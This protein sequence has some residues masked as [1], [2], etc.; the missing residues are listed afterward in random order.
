MVKIAVDIDTPVAD[1]AAAYTE[2]CNMRFDLNDDLNQKTCWFAGDCD[3]FE[4]SKEQDDIAFKEFSDIRM[5]AALKL[6]PGAKEALCSLSGMGYEIIYITARPKGMRRTTAKWIV[7]HGLPLDGLVFESSNKG[8]IASSIGCTYAIDDRLDYCESFVK[9]GIITYLWQKP[10]SME[11][12]DLDVL[13][14]N[15]E[16]NCDF[17]RWREILK[18]IHERER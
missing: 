10:Y 3:N 9:Q 2:Y 12:G 6:V 4:I 1:F 14:I 11:V 7:K 16:K 13:T 15:N 8:K 5:F 18:D 17:E